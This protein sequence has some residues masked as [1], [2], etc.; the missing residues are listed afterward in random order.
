MQSI[1]CAQ[2]QSDILPCDEIEHDDWVTEDGCQFYQNGKLIL[3]ASDLS[4]KQAARAAALI[5]KRQQ[6]WPNVW[7][8]SDHGNLQQMAF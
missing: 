3:D 6:W 1:S 5:M 2:A 4:D 7:F 8:L